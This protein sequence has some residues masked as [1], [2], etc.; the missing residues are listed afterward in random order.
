ML[1]LEGYAFLEMLAGQAAIAIDNSELFEHL[2]SSNAELGMA[3]DYVTLLL[4]SFGL[5]LL[6]IA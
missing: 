4:S 1:Q 2:Q 5:Q 6:L 3:Y